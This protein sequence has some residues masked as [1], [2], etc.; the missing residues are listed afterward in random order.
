MQMSKARTS[1]ETHLCA[2]A[3][4]FLKDAKRAGPAHVVREQLVHVHPD[5]VARFHC[6]VLRVRAK[7]FLCKRTTRADGAR[8]SWPAHRRRCLYCPGADVASGR[9]HLDD[10]NSYRT[11]CPLLLYEVAR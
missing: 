1:G 2:F 7:Y 5:V 8:G 3:K 4:L 9:A 10:N 6:L 11:A